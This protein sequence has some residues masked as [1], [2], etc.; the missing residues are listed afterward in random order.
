MKGLVHIYCGDG[1]GKTT[2]SLGLSIRMAGRG[3]QVAIV[4]FLKST[5]TGELEILNK[6]PN[7]QV[8]RSQENLGFTFRMNEEQ[9]KHA[10]QIQQQLFEKAVSLSKDCDLL[11]LDEIMAAINTNMISCQQVEDLIVNKPENLELVLTGRNP[12]QSLIDLADYVSEIQKIKH[13]FDH[14]IPVRDGVER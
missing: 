12:P 13:P 2:S 3:G 4:Q 14:G 11:V 5:A 8:V 1:K 7:I 9:K 6:I 10:A